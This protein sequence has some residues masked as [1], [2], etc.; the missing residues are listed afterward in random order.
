MRLD[1]FSV[2]MAVKVKD[3]YG[4][5]DLKPPSGYEFVN[6]RFPICGEEYLEVNG[7]PS[8]SMVA[9]GSR[10]RLILRRIQEKFY[11][12]VYLDPEIL[13]YPKIHYKDEKGFFI[14]EEVQCP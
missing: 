13:L 7:I 8:K 11:K 9:K 5:D 4:T 14:L 1:L 10:P 6:F 3:I 12:K 2:H